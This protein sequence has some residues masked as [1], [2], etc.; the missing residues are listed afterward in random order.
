[1]ISAEHRGYDKAR[2]EYL[3]IIKKLIPLAQDGIALHRKN[4]VHWES[5][6]DKSHLIDYAKG[7]VTEKP[8]K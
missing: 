5:L 1:M 7:L 3:D 8:S 2:E 6:R 4:G